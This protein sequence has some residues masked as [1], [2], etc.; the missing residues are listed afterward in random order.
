MANETRLDR[1]QKLGKDY[2]GVCQGEQKYYEK[3]TKVE[4]IDY[5]TRMPVFDL[6]LTS[7][8]LEPWQKQ[9][10]VNFDN[11]FVIACVGKQLIYSADARF[12]GAILD[13]K[14][15]NAAQLIMESYKP[16]VRT[17]GGGRVKSPETI[18]RKLVE[19]SKG[20]LDYRARARADLK[21]KLAILD[22][23]GDTVEDEAT[24]E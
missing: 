18:T 10:S 19:Q 21:A 16:G 6:G 11:D 4:G 20:D 7:E 5:V 23:M 9:Y 24:K 2:K 8:Q 22:A 14:S 13:G 1:A 3:A 17:L 15:H 12:K